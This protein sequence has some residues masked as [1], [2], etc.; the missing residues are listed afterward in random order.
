MT[1]N[2]ATVRCS[3]GIDVSKDSLD[4]FIDAPAEEYRVAN[5]TGDIAALAERL[6]ASAPDHVVVKASGGIESALV[7]ALAA[8][9]LTVCR[10]SP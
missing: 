6:K 8:S 10:V 9:G 2:P 3:A 5:Q 4:I 1:D 7:T